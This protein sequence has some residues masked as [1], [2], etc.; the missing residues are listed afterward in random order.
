MW[1][2]C[3]TNCGRA[4]MAEAVFIRWVLPPT[5]RIPSFEGWHRGLFCGSVAGA[6]A[7]RSLLIRRKNIAVRTYSKWYG[8]I[9]RRC[10]AI[11]P[12]TSRWIIRIE[13]VR[14]QQEVFE[15]HQP[16]AWYFGHFHVN[17]EFLIGGAK[18]RCL[19][20]MSECKAAP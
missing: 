3:W 18:F 5:G 4:V 1:Q 2:E 7:A 12:S 6:P 19:A 9:V 16:S 15:A 14:A 17:R 20:E 10:A 13:T 8:S 11:A